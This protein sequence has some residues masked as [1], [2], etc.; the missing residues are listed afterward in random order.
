MVAEYEGIIDGRTSRMFRMDVWYT[1]GTYKP[2]WCA[3]C[4]LHGSCAVLTGIDHIISFSNICKML[5]DLVNY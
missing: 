3:N 1:Y 5:I 2:V 4:M